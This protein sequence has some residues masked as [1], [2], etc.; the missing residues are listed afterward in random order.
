MHG[1]MKTSKLFTLFLLTIASHTLV[2]NLIVKIFLG[3]K[4][5]GAEE[6]IV[7]EIKIALNYNEYAM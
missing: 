5:R 7:F 3:R 1:S 4:E 2:S 6:Q